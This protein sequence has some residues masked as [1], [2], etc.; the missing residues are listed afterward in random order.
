MAAGKA[1]LDSL[2]YFVDELMVQGIRQLAPWAGDHSEEQIEELRKVTQDRRDGNWKTLHSIGNADPGYKMELDLDANRRLVERVNPLA[3]QASGLADSPAQLAAWCRRQI[4][5]HCR[6]TVEL[7]DRFRYDNGVTGNAQLAVV[8][9]LCPEGPTSGTVGMYLGAALRKH[10]ADLNRQ[11]QLV[12]WGIELC[13]PL[14]TTSAGDFDAL[15]TQSAFRG[16]VARQELLR[17][18]P[19]SESTDDDNYQQPFD[20]NLVFDGGTI[21]RSTTSSTEDIWKAMDRAA[22]QTT[23]CLLNGAAGGDGDETARWLKQAR[24]WNAFM[25]QVVSERSYGNACRYLSYQVN[26]PWHRDRAEWDRTKTS[27]QKDAF[28]RRIDRDL[29]PRLKDEKNPAVKERIQWLVDTAEEARNVKWD[30]MAIVKNLSGRE[31]KIQGLLQDAISGDEHRYSETCKENPAPEIITPKIDPF[32]L[33]ID[34]PE[35]LRREAAVYMRDHSLQR[36][37]AEVLGTNGVAAVRR[38]IEEL[39][40]Q[41]LSRS[42]CRSSDIDSQAR[43]EQIVSLSI[44]DLDKSR[45]NLSFRPS[46][47]FLRDFISADSREDSGCYSELSHDLSVKMRPTS[48]GNDDDSLQTKTLGWNVKGIDYDIPVEYGFLVLARVRQEDG[49][50]DVSTYDVLKE[51]YDKLT[52]NRERWR[53]HARYYGCKPPRELQD[54]V[55]DDHCDDATASANNGQVAHPDLIPENA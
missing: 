28:L 51:E 17:G 48:Q 46:R 38:R 29:L 2:P 5:Q 40:S 7:W 27:Q 30:Q 52:A 1:G 3:A 11:D 31:K 44:T 35:G 39:C 54:V 25:V 33:N 4:W 19:L 32:C 37:I 12:V 16:Y 8:I 41:V 36:P 34:M 23:A 43:F 10:F 9:P 21:T 50:R 6:D 45:E 15:G 13:P 47:E 42:D 14:V 49:F 20:I 18:V 22:A 24:R 53:E 26:L 55:S